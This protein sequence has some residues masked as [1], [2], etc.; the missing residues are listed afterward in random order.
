MAA[1]RLAAH[2]LRVLLILA[3]LAIAGS[4]RAAVGRDTVP[5]RAPKVAPVVPPPPRILKT[6]TLSLKVALVD[7]DMRVRPVPLHAMVLI[8]P[9][10]DTVVIRTGVD[11]GATV[12]LPPGAYR[13]ESRSTASF[14]GR[15]F[16]WS[17]PLSIVSGKTVEIALSN[18]DA[19]AEA[20]PPEAAP[21]L[22]PERTDP[23]TT[24]YE[25][26]KGSVFRVEAGL[27]HGT[28]FLADTLGGVILTNAHVVES[29]EPSNLSVQLDAGTRV[30]AQLL[31]RD[32]DADIA[33]LRIHPQFLAGRL[34]MRLQDPIGRAPA[35]PGERLIAMGYP[36]HQ[37]LSITSGIASSVRAGAILSDVNIN[38]GNSGGPLLNVEGEVIAV[39]TFGDMPS[40]GAGVSGSILVSRA[41]PALARAAAEVQQQ[42]SITADS[43]PVMPVEHLS[44]TALK[45]HADT[46]DL[47]LYR[48]YSDIAVGGFDL[49]V[50]TP[51]QTFV[52]LKVF[53]NEIAKDRKKREA[54]AGL[55]EEQRYSE[56]REYRD[57]AEYVGVP[58]T[59]V[60][61]FA[62]IPK[63]GETGGS[64][65]ARMLI[66]PYLRANYK[67]QGDVRGAQVFRDGEPVEAIR[68]GHAPTKVFLENQWVS[69]KDVADQGFYAYDAELLRPDSNGVAPS[70]VVAVQDLKHPNSAKCRVIPPE[71]IARAWN[72][73]EHFYRDVKPEV[74]YW[75]A[76]VKRSKDDRP[77]WTN[78]D[79]ER[80]C[81]WYSIRGSGGRGMK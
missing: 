81:D 56:V 28:G 12:S 36:L 40:R 72:D 60:V 67:F 32:A 26:L 45:A 29:A 11:G 57:W 39:N 41:G 1:C 27:A 3:I 80:E 70:I 52:S 35:L 9:A 13:L 43:L 71:V 18:D 76:D 19:T 22:A 74:A 79:L 49:T 75:R 8:G 64:V 38:P 58:T 16:R 62:I 66:S 61:A 46:V 51:A 55:S 20:T 44:I 24:L 33:V 59:P 2:A 17:I 42:H 30:R 68:G 10:L 63:V 65:F 48:G 7:R 78:Q 6:G 14:E 15:R 50:Q 5:Q 34:R 23:T 54:R 31:A 77:E 47:K 4:A 25:R 73:F 21:G 69:L 37:D 53:E